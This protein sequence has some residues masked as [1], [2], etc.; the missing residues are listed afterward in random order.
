MQKG[1]RRKILAEI[2]YFTPSKSNFVNIHLK[3]VAVYLI[4]FCR[5]QKNIS[6]T[7]TISCLMYNRQ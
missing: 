4:F 5:L 3:K 1:K 6:F 7:A 2:C